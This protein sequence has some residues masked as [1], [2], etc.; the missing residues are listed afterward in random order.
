MGVNG[1]A[2]Y[3][4]T[5]SPFAEQLSFG[6]VTRKGDRL[7]VSVFDWPVERH[8]HA[9]VVGRDAE[10]GVAGRDKGERAAQGG[11]VTA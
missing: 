8:D 11:R 2:I 4:T 1:E 10:E 7:Y 6:R 3:G 5:A 9:A